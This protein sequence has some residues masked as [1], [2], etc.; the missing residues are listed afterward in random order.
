PG[1]PSSEKNPFLATSPDLPEEE[2]KEEEET[3]EKK[4]A[5]DDTSTGPQP[6]Y[7]G[8][9]DSG[10]RPRGMRMM[11]MSRNAVSTVAESSGI[12]DEQLAS[13]IS[14]AGNK[15]VT[16]GA[17]NSAS[18][19]TDEKPKSW[20]NAVWEVGKEKTEWKAAGDARDSE[21][22][23][24]EVKELAMVV[25]SEGSHLYLGQP[26]T[27][28]VVVNNAN[29]YLHAEL[30]MDGGKNG[31]DKLPLAGYGLFEF[32]KLQGKGSITLMGDTAGR[33]TIYSFTGNP[34]EEMGFSGLIR[35]AGSQAAR[36][37][38]NAAGSHWKYAAVD[39]DLGSGESYHKKDGSATYS[40]QAIGTIL[41][42]TGNA[43]F[44]GLQ[45]GDAKNSTV[46]SN[47]GDLSYT[48]TLGDASGEE[49]TYNGTFNGAYYT[50][51]T[52]S[53]A[54]AAPLN[55]TKVYGNTQ[56][57]TGDA[58]GNNAFNI[59]S[60]QG[61][62]L[63]FSKSLQSAM[64]EAAGG[65]LSVGGNL[66]ITE[67]YAEKDELKVAA[68]GVINVTGDITVADDASVTGGGRLSA[69]N[70]TVNDKMSVD[71]GTVTISGATTA[72]SLRVYGGGSLS[73]KDLQD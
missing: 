1:K 7:M 13:L 63:A 17:G 41:N 38:L 59:V 42:I 49:Y 36:V 18:V 43:Q 66:N 46:T 50:S 44:L 34:G 23:G 64:A 10:E 39:M 6:V 33:T 55:L 15:A 45:G 68:G 56:V 27:A 71:G 28:D 70:L 29:A 61:G 48:L 8:P 19:H 22:K 51:G 53:Y 47:S 3:T 57:M 67:T 72:Q 37:Q 40:G 30:D 16:V 73:T 52:A 32:D 60:A 5:Q 12:T 11:A 2:E 58:T 24:K 65:T 9:M 26:T 21:I 4:T 35:M 20:K 54:S 31:K 62:T 14:Q 25:L 69:A